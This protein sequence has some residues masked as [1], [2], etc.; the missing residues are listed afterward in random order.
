MKKIRFFRV[1][2]V[3]MILWLL[4]YTIAAIY[5]YPSHSGEAAEAFF[6]G[7]LGSGFGLSFIYIVTGSF[8]FPKLPD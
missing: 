4:V 8:A 2:W 1:L 3:V 5:I 7:A 6:I